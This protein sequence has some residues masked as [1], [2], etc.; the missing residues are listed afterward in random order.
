MQVC[1]LLNAEGFIKVSSVSNLMAKKRMRG[2]C[3]RRGAIEL[4]DT[5]YSTLMGK[6]QKADARASGSI[7][8]R[9]VLSFSGI[10]LLTMVGTAIGYGAL[11]RM[12]E[13]TESMVHGNVLTEQMV[14]DAYLQ[15]S[16][17]TERYK[18]MALSSE[19]EVGEVLAAD[20]AKTQAKF[21]RLIKDI[22]PRL[23]HAEERVIW[24]KIVSAGEKF[25]KAQ[26]ELVK[27]RDSGLTER[28]QKVY[29][30][31]FRPASD[32]MLAAIADL[33]VSQRSAVDSGAVDVLQASE[34]ARHALILFTI[35]STVAGLLLALSLVRRISQPIQLANAIANRVARLDLREDIQGHER[36]EAG[37]LMASLGTM[38]E[39]LRTLVLQVRDSAHAIRT[40]S[41]DIA[42]GNAD[43]SERT[44]Q[45]A[46][47]LQQTAAALEQITKIVARSAEFA[48]VA[49]KMAASATLVAQEGGESVT[50]MVVTMKQ[51]EASSHQ[52]VDIIKVIDAIAF[53]TNILALNASVEAARAGDHGLGFAVVAAEVRTLANRSA[54]AAM[55]IKAL[56]EA[57]VQRAAAGSQLAEIAGRSMQR[58][59]DSSSTLSQAISDI[60]SA[61]KAQTEDI[62]QINSAV[63]LLDKMTQQNSALV[64]QSAASSERLHGHANDLAGLISQ[65]LHPEALP[66]QGARFRGKLLSVNA[67]S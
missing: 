20:I 64:E 67:R 11:S 53:Q 24:D 54:S 31:S 3:I 32:E 23:A 40:A 28:I 2:N 25:Q 7:G 46:S 44:E 41:S 47:S 65:F 51:M 22:H 29:G 21:E 43:L 5:I 52:I 45:T 36:D 19:P 26:V 13:V 60:T 15:Q 35:A 56:I 16:I 39:A 14:S 57:S 55:D 49:E 62:S 12:N 34:Y 66:D 58:I 33:S 63:S 18:A 48:H 27:A 37:Q 4:P 61:A 6:S 10:S 30:E 59:V 42:N 9:L 38:Q 50:K 1:G 8:R 17:N